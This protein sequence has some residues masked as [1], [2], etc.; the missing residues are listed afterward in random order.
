[1]SAQ[2]IVSNWGLTATI[3]G[4]WKKLNGNSRKNRESGN[5]TKWDLQS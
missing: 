1:M 3:S 4:V 5:S 2:S